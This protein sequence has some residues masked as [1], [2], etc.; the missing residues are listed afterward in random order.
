[1]NCCEV[2]LK[3]MRGLSAVLPA[4]S[5]NS[6]KS[7]AGASPHLLHLRISSKLEDKTPPSAPVFHT[8]ALRFPQSR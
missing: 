2:R 8:G 6:K 7:F 4:I 5:L 3:L 1:M